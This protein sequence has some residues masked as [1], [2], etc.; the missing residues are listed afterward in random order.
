MTIW[1]THDPIGSFENRLEIL[2]QVEACRMIKNIVLS[3]DNHPH[4]VENL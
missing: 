2:G 1:L 4:L 3:I